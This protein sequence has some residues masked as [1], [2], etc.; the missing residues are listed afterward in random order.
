[1]NWIQD[2]IETA[3]HNSND[4][5]EYYDD[6]VRTR[7]Y[8]EIE[9]IRKTIDSVFNNFCFNNGLFNRL[10]TSKLEQSEAGILKMIGWNTEVKNRYL[11]KMINYYYSKLDKRFDEF[12]FEEDFKDLLNDIYSGTPCVYVQRKKGLLPKDDVK[13]VLF[14][15]NNPLIPLTSEFIKIGQSIQFDVE[16]F[17]KN[18]FIYLLCGVILVDLSQKL[19]NKNL[20]FRDVIQHIINYLHILTNTKAFDLSRINFNDIEGNKEGKYN[21]IT[22]TEFKREGKLIPNFRYTCAKKYFEEN[23]GKGQTKYI[24]D[25]K[26]SYIL[27]EYSTNEEV[28]KKWNELEELWKQDGLNDSLIKTW[29]DSQ[30]LTRSTCLVGV[31]LMIVRSMNK[32]KLIKFKKDEMPDWKAISGHEIN[33]TYEESGDYKNIDVKESDFSVGNVLGLLN[34][35][36]NIIKSMK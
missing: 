12:S 8:G 25:E 9:N 28:M 34:N 35:Y 29:F 16:G 7:E 36:S 27:T 31:L 4:T 30:L 22:F 32:G 19:K 20:K 24:S 5:M 17:T 33:D 18:Q 3:Q 26:G 23:K 1:M 11:V 14:P 21:L 6:I 15:V 10:D 2:F 13:S